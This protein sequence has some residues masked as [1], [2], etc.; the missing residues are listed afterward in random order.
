MARVSAKFPEKLVAELKSRLGATVESEKL[1]G[2]TRYSFLVISDKF[3]KKSP[4][5]R[6]EMVWKIV[7]DS[8][9]QDEAFKI[10]IILP[11]EPSEVEGN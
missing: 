3:K 4:A 6:Q 5:R 11:V 2:S 10:S 1:P 8:L 9:S 7:D